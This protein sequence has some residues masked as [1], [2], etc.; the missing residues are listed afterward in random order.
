[1]K[2]FKFSVI[3]L[4]IAFAI[5][6]VITAALIIRQNVVDI[7]IND[8]VSAMT[9]NVKYRNKV[10]IIGVPVIKQEIS[11]GYACIEMLSEYLGGNGALTE[12]ILYERNGNKITTSTNDGLYKEMQKRLPDY[13]IT[14][15]KNLKNSE[16]IDMIYESLTNGMPV[17]FSYAAFDTTLDD[18]KDNPEWT[19]HYGIAV[20]MNIPGNEI[21]VNNPYGYTETYGISDFLKATRFESYDNMEFYLKLGFGA[22]I[23]SKNT[24]Y[25]I[26]DL[27]ADLNDT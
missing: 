20:G 23:F 16:L 26:E 12:E 17:I 25:I 11:C 15:H 18:A 9:H 13:K 19:L 7:M 6:F 21:T 22:G 14:Q 8:N 1:M 5:G 3:F 27:P 24:V 10:K 4:C 2:I